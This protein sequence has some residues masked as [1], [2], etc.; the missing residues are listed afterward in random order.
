M[1]KKIVH[2]R[3]DWKRGK[4]MVRIAM[5]VVSNK[6]HEI[7]DSIPISARAAEALVA[8]GMNSEG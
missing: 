8:S 6:Q 2:V 3:W 7:L 5:L 1:E 4:K